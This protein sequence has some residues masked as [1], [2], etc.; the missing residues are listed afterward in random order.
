[1]NRIKALIGQL[2]LYLFPKNCFEE[3]LIK[4]NVMHREYIARLFDRS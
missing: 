3:L 2:I 4:L 1:M